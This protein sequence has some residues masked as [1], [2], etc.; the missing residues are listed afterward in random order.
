MG[1]EFEITP[2][3]A[4]AGAYY[5]MCND[6]SDLP[7]EDIR[8]LAIEVFEVMWQAR[9]QSQCIIPQRAKSPLE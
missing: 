3:M 8:Q 2:Q 4:D 6:I 7:P 5:L 1:A 9:S